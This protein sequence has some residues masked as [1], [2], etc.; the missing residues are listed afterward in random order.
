MNTFRRV[1]ERTVHQGHLW[2]VAVATVEAPDG[3]RFERDVVLSPGAVGVVPVLADPEGGFAVVLVRQYRAAVDADVLEIPAGMCDVT[4]EPAETTAGRELVEEAGLAAGR[5][6]RLAVFHNAIGMTNHF[7]Y[8]SLATELTPADHDRQGAEEQAMEVV[9]LPLAD[10]LAM[11]ERGEITDA[12]TV[13]GLLLADRRLAA[14][15]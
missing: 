15:T 6:E 14:C 8:L 1:A 2:R 7:T 12:K 10:A 13:I 3:E 11:V 9:Q 5:L 4:D